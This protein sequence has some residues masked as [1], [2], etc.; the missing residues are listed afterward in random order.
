M[1]RIAIIFSEGR[2]GGPQKRIIELA[3]ALLENPQLDIT[4]I[5]P[6]NNS[7]IFESELFNRNLEFLKIPISG[8]NFNLK[9]II[10]YIIRF[11]PD[12]LCLNKIINKGKYDLIDV[13]GGGLNIKSI[14]AGVLS[15]T[16]I[17]WTFED[18]Y[19]PYIINQSIKIF[20]GF[21]SSFIVASNS[22]LNYYKDAIGHKSVFIVPAP[23]DINYFCR[24]GDYNKFKKTNEIVI[25]TV[26]NIN[27]IKNIEL[28][29]SISIKLR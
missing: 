10:N 26:A 16:K 15:R 7:K 9:S 1:Y 3:N 29:L 4:I 21:C 2:I 18:T 20:S 11:F 27:P 22:T 8:I 6:S 14:I 5:I 12:I 17:V 19:V 23:I 24:E 25:G 28:I 13:I